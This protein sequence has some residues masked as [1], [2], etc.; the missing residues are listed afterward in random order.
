MLND[1]RIELSPETRPLDVAG[2]D[3][4]ANIT[5]VYA[6]EEEFGMRFDDAD[7]GTARSIGELADRIASACAS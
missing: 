6:L 1:D 4:L 2:W 3:S 5:I 7:L